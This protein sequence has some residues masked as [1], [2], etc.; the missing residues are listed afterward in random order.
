M[1]FGGDF[2]GLTGERGRGFEVKN[3]K[4]RRHLL[5]MIP[6]SQPSFHHLSSF[7]SKQLCKLA[8]LGSTGAGEYFPVSPYERK[9]KR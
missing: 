2:Q 1:G 3:Q 4:M 6:V 8:N 5:R 7:S 9:V